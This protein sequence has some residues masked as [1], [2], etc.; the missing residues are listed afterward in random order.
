MIITLV[1]KFFKVL[2]FSRGPYFSDELAFKLD[3]NGLNPAVDKSWRRKVS[4]FDGVNLATFRL[5]QRLRR[6]LVFSHI[7]VV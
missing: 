3:V 7:F 6:A 4:K 2:K 5:L 1:L